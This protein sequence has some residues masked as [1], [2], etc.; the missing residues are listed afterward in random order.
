[1]GIEK[2]VL[3]A[4]VPATPIAPLGRNGPEPIDD[5]VVLTIF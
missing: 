4:S 5:Q 1:M 2:G 3:K